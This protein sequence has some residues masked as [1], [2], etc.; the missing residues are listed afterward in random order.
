M[1]TFTLVRFGFGKDSTLGYLAEIVGGEER[2]LAYI[3]EDERRHTKV[4]GETCIPTGTYTLGLQTVGKNHDKYKARF[5]DW[6]KGMIHV[7]DVPGFD[8]IHFHP[9][10]RDDDTLGCLL[11]GDRAEILD[12]CEFAIAGGTSVP[13]YRRI[14]ETIVPLLIAGEKVVLHITEMQP[15]A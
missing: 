7:E 2:R 10:N 5:P 8:G 15:W 4:Y 6:H 12:G 14:Y 11:T 3:L 13:A 1:R 9:G